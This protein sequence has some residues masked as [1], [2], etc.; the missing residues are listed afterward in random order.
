MKI[1]VASSWKNNIQ[2]N[3]VKQLRVLGHNVYDFKNPEFGFHWSDITNNEELVD[4][5]KY[6]DFLSHPV[7]QVAF[8]QLTYIL[9][10]NPISEPELMYYYEFSYLHFSQRTFGF[11]KVNESRTFSPKVTQV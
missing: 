3:V 11:I 9:L 10:D 1:Y 6:R 4:P 7:A 8:N 5:E 2:P